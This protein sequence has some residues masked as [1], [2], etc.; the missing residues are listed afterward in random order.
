MMLSLSQPSSASVSRSTIETGVEDAEPLTDER[1][2]LW[3]VSS[4]SL[5]SISIDIVSELLVWSLMVMSV[6][7]C[8]SIDLWT[9][10]QCNA[11][12]HELASNDRQLTTEQSRPT[13]N[14]S[15]VQC[16]QYIHRTKSQDLKVRTVFI[17]TFVRLSTVTHVFYV[18][19]SVS[20]QWNVG[21]KDTKQGQ[22]TKDQGTNDR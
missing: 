16:S 11:H 5:S 6:V 19:G 22:R 10:R 2:S 3:K 12:I 9:T 4:I 20:S 14:P 15:A 17:L 13:H 7:C 21:E 8:C 1:M 18:P